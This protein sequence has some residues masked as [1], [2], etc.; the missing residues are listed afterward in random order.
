MDKFMA[1]LA[2]FAVIAVAS[3]GFMFGAHLIK[4]SNE[5]FQEQIETIEHRNWHQRY[6]H[7]IQNA[8]NAPSCPYSNC[9]NLE[10]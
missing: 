10:G 3:M 5:D 8:S 9:N 7:A 2:L 4:D 6:D 1:A